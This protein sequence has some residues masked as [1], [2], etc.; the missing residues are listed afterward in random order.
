MV[1]ATRRIPEREETATSSMLGAIPVRVVREG[2]DKI[3]AQAAQ[4]SGATY[5]HLT[6]RPEIRRQ[7]AG[8]ELSAI[9]G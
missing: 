1:E 3:A 9:F 6:Q 7:M 5:V 4:I 8:S 2:Y